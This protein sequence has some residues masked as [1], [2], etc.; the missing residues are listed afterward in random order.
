[1]YYNS[2]YLYELQSHTNL[3]Y[4]H[5][6]RL[7]DVTT[8]RSIGAERAVLPLRVNAHFCHL[9]S[10][11]LTFWPAPLTLRFN[12][13]QLTLC[14]QTNMSINL[15]QTGYHGMQF[16]L[17]IVV[18]KPKRNWVSISWIADFHQLLT[19][20]QSLC[21]ISVSRRV[22]L[23]L[24]IPIPSSNVVLGSGI[25]TDG[26]STTVTLVTG[27]T[28]W[29]CAILGM[30][31][32]KRLKCCKLS[33]HCELLTE[34][35]GLFVSYIALFTRWHDTIAMLLTRADIIIHQHVQWR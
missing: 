10:A 24:V 31:N 6:I 7:A 35:V 13:L 20:E 21:V 4:A 19:S 15:S 16:L 33:R 29:E 2:H 30:Q 9:R 22:L 34:C 3:L 25:S 11:H 14:V 18:Q 27:I 28:S 5:R 1:M 12:A 32:G 23:D 26:N 17:I 8:E